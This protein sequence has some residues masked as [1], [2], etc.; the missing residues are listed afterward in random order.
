MFQNVLLNV[1]FF[2]WANFGGQI[3]SENKNVLVIFFVESTLYICTMY[4]TVYIIL[5]L[6]CNDKQSLT[7]LFVFC[8][9]CDIWGIMLSCLY[10]LHIPHPWP[11]LYTVYTIQY[12][13]KTISSNPSVHKSWTLHLNDLLLYTVQCT[14]YSVLV[15]LINIAKYSGS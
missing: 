15:L 1:K 3:R 8:E 2:T 9:S 10:E 7:F 14:V 4:R 6:L 12:F 11:S 13:Q 5:Y